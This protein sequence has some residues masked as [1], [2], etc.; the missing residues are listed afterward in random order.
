[1]M[2]LATLS[3]FDALPLPLLSPSPPLPSPLPPP[4]PLT[5][6]TTFVLLHFRL[7][8]VMCEREVL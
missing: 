5:P 6:P 8:R 1:M 4:L 2:A 3:C 7:W